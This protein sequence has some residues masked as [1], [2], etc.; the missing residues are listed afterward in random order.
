M[1]LERK[2]NDYIVLNISKNNF[3]SSTKTNW[4]AV[5]INKQLKFK[6]HS[7]TAQK[8]YLDTLHRVRNY[9]T[10]KKVKFLANAFIDSQFNYAPLF[11]VFTDKSSILKMCKIYFQTLQANYNNYD[12][13][14]HDLL[15]FNNGFSI[16]QRHL[17]FPAIELYKSVV[18]VGIFQ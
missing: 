1:V 15:N 8:E 10:V 13:S 9:L 4:L 6:S 7:Q 3:Q 5:E 11:W 16:H 18:N 17:R 2:E 12:K 14:Y